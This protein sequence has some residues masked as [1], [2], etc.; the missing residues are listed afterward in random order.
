[1]LFLAC[2][3]VLTVSGLGQPVSEVCIFDHYTE[4]TSFTARIE[5]TGDDCTGVTW[6]ILTSEW[7]GYRISKENNFEI[8]EDNLLAKTITSDDATLEAENFSEYGLFAVK[9]K[10][11]HRNSYGIDG[12]SE[13]TV[14]DINFCKIFST[15][16]MKRYFSPR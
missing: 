15:E 10:I 14:S 4:T 16:L 2:S 7:T 9:A 11:N 8:L 1:M 3:P 12:S 13:L 5:G 6:T